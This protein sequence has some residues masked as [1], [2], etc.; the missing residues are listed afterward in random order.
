MGI[1]MPHYPTLFFLSVGGGVVGAIGVSD[2]PTAGWRSVMKHCRFLG[3]ASP[4]PLEPAWA[5]DAK[6]FGG[7]YRWK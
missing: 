5:G 3:G 4:A 7:V 6:D 1:K 2:G